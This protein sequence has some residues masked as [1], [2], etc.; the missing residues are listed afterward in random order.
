MR[1]ACRADCLQCMGVLAMCSAGQNGVVQT[2]AVSGHLQK[3]L[4]LLL[5][6]SAAHGSTTS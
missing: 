6:D 3:Q 4:I 1:A 2:S 5:S